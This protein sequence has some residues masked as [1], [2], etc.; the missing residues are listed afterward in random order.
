MPVKTVTIQYYAA[1]REQRGVAQESLKT[2]ALTL[3]ELY[4]NLKSQYNFPYSCE[5]L[6]VAVNDEF[7]H[8]QSPITDSDCIIFIP[9]VAGG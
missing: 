9:P 1:L 6:R 3:E 4:L 5:M 2:T 7:V 8:W